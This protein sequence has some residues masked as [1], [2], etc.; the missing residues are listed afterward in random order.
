MEQEFVAAVVEVE[1]ELPGASHPF[2]EVAILEILE[3]VPFLEGVDA[4]VLAVLVATVEYPFQAV[5][6]A[7]VAS[8]LVEVA[9]CFQPS[10]ASREGYLAEW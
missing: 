10:K 4:S 8:V 3:V 6:F 9:D 7:L 5:E 2:V 1:R